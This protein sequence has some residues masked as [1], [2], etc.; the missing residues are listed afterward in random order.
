[1][2]RTPLGQEFLTSG[3]ADPAELRLTRC[4]ILAGRQ[5]PGAPAA[6]R[7]VG[8]LGQEF[9]WGEAPFLSTLRGLKELSIM[10]PFFARIT[11]PQPVVRL[12]AQVFEVIQREW[13]TDGSRIE[14]KRTVTFRKPLIRF[15]GGQKCHSFLFLARK[16]KRRLLHLFAVAA[17]HFRGDGRTKGPGTASRAEQNYRQMTERGERA[18]RGSLTREADCHLA[19]SL[20]SLPLR[21]LVGVA[22]LT[23]H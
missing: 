17:G 15:W 12:C 2:G 23:F 21:R 18:G 16:Y 7:V 13:M 20:F 8:P 9:N 10:L 6:P 3:G 1:M 19:V 11:P 4:M 22:L 14:T 5:K